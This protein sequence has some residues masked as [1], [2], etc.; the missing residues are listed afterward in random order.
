LDFLVMVENF[1]VISS[2]LVR[3]GMEMDETWDRYNPLLRGQQIR[4][5]R[6]GILV[7]LLRPRDEHDRQIF[8][9][10]RRKCFAKK[11]FWFVSPEDFILQKLKVGR[12]QDFEDAVAVLQKPGH[13][14]DRRY[15]LRWAER[16]G[17]SGELDYVLNL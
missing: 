9:R 15:L 11:Y 7:D 16:L 6:H 2:A 3:A 12:P 13:V 5:K 14:L 4:L 8:R 17:I 10:R 1:E